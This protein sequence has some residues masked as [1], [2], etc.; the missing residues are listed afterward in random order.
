MAAL[1]AW[2]LAGTVLPAALASPCALAQNYPA[3]DFSVVSLVGTAPSMLIAHPGVT[4][5]TVKDLIDL[6]KAKPAQLNFASAGI[7]TPPH[8]AGEL[9]NSMTGIKPG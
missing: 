7:G 4:I 9:F 1:K 8:L 2:M 6:A 5:R 3:K